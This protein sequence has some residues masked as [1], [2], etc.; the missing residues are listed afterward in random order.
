M[1]L[2]VIHVYAQTC[3]NL[4][5]NPGTAFPVCGTDT[6]TQGS[7]PICGGKSVPGPCPNIVLADLNPYW[8]KFTCFAAGSLGFVISPVNNTDDYDWQLFD[9]TNKDPA[10]LYTDVSMFVA[11][12]W[13][14]DP[15]NTGASAAGT[16]L[17]HCDGYGVPLFSSMPTLIEGHHYILLVSHFSGGAQSGYTL[18]FGGGS[19]NITDPVD[20]HLSAARAA[21]DGSAISIKLNKKM[22]CGSLNADGSDFTL[23]PATV[24]I[25][26]ATGIGCS[27]SFD[28]DSV[29][30]KLGGFLAPGNYKVTVRAT[31]NLLDNCDKMLPS[32]DTLN[33]T[34][35][36]LIPT[37][38]DSLEKVA[39]APDVLRLVF[40]DPMKCSSI[41]T[42]GSDFLVTGTSA[43]NVVAAAGICNS[44]GLADIIEVKL[45]TP[46]QQA[47]NFQI[48]LQTGNDGNSII[49]ECGKET[50]PGVA[51]SFTTKDTVSAVFTT[52]IRYG[53]VT[54]TVLY[55]HDG[56]NGV[57]NWAWTFDNTINSNAQTNPVFYTVFG[58]KDATLIVSN[59]TC[60]DTATAS[61]LLN[62]AINAAFEST[63][64]VCPGDPAI[65]VDKSSGILNNQ[66]LWD[67]GN[68]ATSTAQSP[69]NQYYPLSDNIHDVLVRLVITN[70]IGCKDTAINT[71]TVAGNCYIA[72]P[73][74]FSPNGDGLNDYLYPTNAY[75]A[76]DLIFR[77]YNRP[78]QLVFETRNW[79]NKW[80]GTFKGNPQDP[81]TYI[82]ILN[83]T[84]ID[85][86]KK[87]SLKG[88]TVL[89][90]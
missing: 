77:V 76:K 47:G 34:V 45:S 32:G 67:F 22:K 79:M 20:P 55:S 13:S 16:S 80:D 44:D 4:G 68:G 15:G 63:P 14:G 43:V 65:F 6:F 31:E 57:N 60:S 2:P 74:A 82:W 58:Q 36:P 69:A 18:T 24:P 30:L 86:G 27:S 21:C 52:S 12:D 66:W 23:L 64:V 90:R 7:V 35:Y 87:I 81:G 5:Q 17:Q 33:V 51:I 46:I 29:V 70:S 37:P 53:C 56:K 10:N 78:G 1:L 84:N 3:N 50:P 26:G 42:D 9:V 41:A 39:C 28:M 83:Y 62:N 88:S 38:F 72:V 8:Y 40:R 71:I 59:G 49:N 75:K 11:C 19:A 25:I 85:T 73:K 48:K 54:D 61:L 89:L